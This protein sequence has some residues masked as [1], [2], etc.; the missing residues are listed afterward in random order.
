MPRKIRELENDLRQ[1]GFT[2]RPGKGSHR[3][4]KHPLVPGRITMSG[5]GGDD[6]QPYQ[7]KEVQDKLGQLREA[8]ER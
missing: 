4:W 7:E 8:R 1:A 2:A 6:A 5:K 3:V